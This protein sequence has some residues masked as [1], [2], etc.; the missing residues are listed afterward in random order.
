[1]PTINGTF[2]GARLCN[3]AR[4]TV[5]LTPKTDPS[6]SSPS[7]VPNGSL[8]SRIAYRIAFR[9]TADLSP[10]G[11]TAI[12]SNGRTATASGV[13]V[14]ED[15]TW[16]KAFSGFGEGGGDTSGA[17]INAILHTK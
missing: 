7:L 14:S 11:G 16:D 2:L 3:A 12:G 1:M 10:L 5:L 17:R 6:S 4:T 13:T 15:R 8:C 9:I